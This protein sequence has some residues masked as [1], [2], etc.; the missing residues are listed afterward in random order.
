[1]GMTQVR[2]EIHLLRLKIRTDSS[3]LSLM[4]ES[5]WKGEIKRKGE[6]AK[7]PAWHK[8]PVSL[9]VLPS[10]FFFLFSLEFSCFKVALMQLPW[11]ASSTCQKVMWHPNA[12][13]VHFWASVFCVG[14]SAGNEYLKFA[15]G[16]VYLEHTLL[17]ITGIWRGGWAVC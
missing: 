14:Q 13:V 6:K 16:N 2:R 4:P 5:L 10:G 17:C 15:H 8:S 12:F 1:M 9:Y 11:I 3:T 7:W